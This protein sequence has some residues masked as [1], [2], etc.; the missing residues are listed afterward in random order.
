MDRVSFTQM[1]DGTADDWAL[2][3]RF[4]EEFNAGLPERILEAVDKLNGSYGGYKV[5]RYTHSLQAATRAMRDGKDE[6][7]LVATLVHDEVFDFG[8]WQALAWLGIFT[9]APIAVTTAPRRRA[10]AMACRPATPTPMIN[11][12][13][14]ATVPAAVIIIGMARP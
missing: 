10:V 13:A 11:T 12:L 4:E 2:L 9:G 1:Q 3:E 5:S 7:Y 6:E 14:A 8:R